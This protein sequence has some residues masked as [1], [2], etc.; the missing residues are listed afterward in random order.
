[1]RRISR[2]GDPPAWTTHGLGDV[3]IEELTRRQVRAWWQSLPV[4]ER[5]ASCHQAYG[6]LRAIMNAAIDVNPARIKGAGK[7]SK[8]RNNDPLP[9]LYAIADE[10]PP[11][12]RL[13][14]LLAGVLG[15]RSGEVRALQRQ[16]F[17]D[18]VLHIQHSIN[19]RDWDNPIGGLK[20]ERSNRRLIIP[21][22]L[23]PDVRDHLLNHTQLGPHGLLFWSADGKPVRSA[24]W[25]KAFKK[26]CQQVADATEDEK[27]KR[28]LTDDGGYIF[29]GTRVTGLTAIYRHSG[30]NLRAVMAVGGHTSATTA[31]RYQRAELDYQRDS[32]GDSIPR[33]RRTG[34][35]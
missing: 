32:D 11:W 21:S 34:V 7:P 27:I 4:V 3:L 18:D 30:G 33:D 5:A 19:K 8:E 12:F 29:H 14:V 24:A 6:L 9:V 16:D 26:A 22:A 23:M 13:G 25:L 15:L 20:T 31:L 10:M 1:V 35:R 28:L 2:P 17:D